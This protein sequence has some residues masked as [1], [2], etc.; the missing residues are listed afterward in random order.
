MLTTILK[1][2]LKD[3]NKD[4][5]G[6]SIAKILREEKRRAASYGRDNRSMIIKMCGI[7]G[8]EY[9]T[10]HPTIMK[11]HKAAKYRIR[12]KFV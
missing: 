4:E 3:D 1:T 12:E 10:G 11:K 6:V 9:K 5:G 7:A 2:T 8:C